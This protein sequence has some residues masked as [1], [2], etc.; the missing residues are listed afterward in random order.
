MALAHHGGAFSG[1]D[2]SKVDRS[3]AYA[4]RWVENI[5]AAGLAH[6][7]EIQIAYALALP[8]RYPSTWKPSAPSRGVTRGQIAAAVR[9]VNLRSAPPP[10]I[11]DELDLKRPIYLKTAATATSAAQTLSSRG[12]K[13][14]KVEELKAAIA[15][16]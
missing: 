8:T 15:A 4:T 10:H 1:K 13:T 3:A 7:V 2:P 9:K 12:K 16:E 14:D 5:V 11:I 6:K